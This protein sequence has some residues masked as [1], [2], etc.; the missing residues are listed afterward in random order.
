M[1]ARGE[2]IKC[3]WKVGSMSI[4]NFSPLNLRFCCH[5]VSYFNTKKKKKKKKKC[6]SSAHSK[7][8]YI[9]WVLIFLVRI[10][11]IIWYVSF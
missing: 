1:L 7:D 10:Q 11:G 6:H 5:S 3:A 2:N 4:L 8:K 9:L